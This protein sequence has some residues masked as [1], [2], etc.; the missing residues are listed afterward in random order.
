MLIATINLRTDVETLIYGIPL[1]LMAGMTL[2]VV[3]TLVGMLFRGR[4]VRRGRGEH[5]RSRHDKAGNELPPMARG[6]CQS[7]QQYSAAIYYLPGGERF[8]E[9]CYRPGRGVK[10]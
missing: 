10:R 8:C 2:A 5:Y 3:W 4:A 7:C 1:M 9:D 6:I